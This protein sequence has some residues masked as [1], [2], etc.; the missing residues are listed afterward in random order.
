M[1]AMRVKA[2]AVPNSA[3]EHVI[4]DASTGSVDVTN[5]ANGGADIFTKDSVNSVLEAAGNT[6]DQPKWM[7]K[8]YLIFIKIKI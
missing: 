3:E 4:Y 5:A 8:I 2:N 7:V 1:P 6:L